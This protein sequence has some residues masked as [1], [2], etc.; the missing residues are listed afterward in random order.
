MM[1][2]NGF[3]N[4][5]PPAAQAVRNAGAAL[6]ASGQIPNVQGG[7][8]RVGRIMF[9]GVGGTNPL[10]VATGHGLGGTV[11]PTAIYA[12]CIAQQAM[13]GQAWVV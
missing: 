10:P 12:T 1:N 13:F 2:A 9:H 11:A 6:N 8:G 5:S 7:G 3:Y 4:P